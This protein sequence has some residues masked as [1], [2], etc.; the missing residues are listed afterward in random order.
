MERSRCLPDQFK[1]VST[2]ECTGTILSD[3]A[4]IAIHPS[5]PWQPVTPNLGNDDQ[6]R[7]SQWVD[8][9]SRRGLRNDSK[10]MMLHTRSK[11]FDH[12]CQPEAR[13]PP[14][15]ASRGSNLGEKTRY[16]SSEL[17]KV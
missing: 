2:P 16:W 7:F 17:N 11:T 12:V 6:Y 1:N 4:S 13:T 8:L 15:E 10:K 14:R 5:A 9:E 3:F